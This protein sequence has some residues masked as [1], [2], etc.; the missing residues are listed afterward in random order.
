MLCNVEGLRAQIDDFIELVLK[1]KTFR[2]I[3][4]TYCV[5]FSNEWIG[6]M[7]TFFLN[8]IHFIIDKRTDNFCYYYQN[9][10]PW[11]HFLQQKYPNPKLFEIFKLCKC[12]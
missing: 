8:F 4:S 10:R 12:V 1:L 2:A 6:F 3:M 11:K 9:L 7:V 5:V